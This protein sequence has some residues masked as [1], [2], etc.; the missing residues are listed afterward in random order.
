MYKSVFCNFCI[1]IHPYT[2]P[3]LRRTLWS[4]VAF[5]KLKKQVVLMDP[6]ATQPKDF[7]EHTC[8]WINNDFAIV[9]NGKVQRRGKVNSSQSK[10]TDTQNN[11]IEFMRADKSDWASAAEHRTVAT[12]RQPIDRAIANTTHTG[13]DYQN[14]ENAEKTEQCGPPGLLHFHTIL[15]IP[16]KSTAN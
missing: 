7:A 4:L 15:L 2:D 13:S 10:T 6:I 12:R 14:N 3:E 1:S 16:C 5:P 9:K 11:K 8:F